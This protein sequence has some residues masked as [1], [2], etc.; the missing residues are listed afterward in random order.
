MSINRWSI[1]STAKYIQAS[2]P[3]DCQV[4]KNRGARRNRPRCGNRQR[5]TVLVATPDD[6]RRLHNLLAESARRTAQVHERWRAAE[7]LRA[8]IPSGYK[9]WRAAENLKASNTSL[10][11]TKHE[12]ERVL[13]GLRA[14]EFRR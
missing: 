13:D 2:T 4:E 14:F 11:C 5:R 10:P 8:R 3:R 1:S 12:T 7:N 9:R 6:L